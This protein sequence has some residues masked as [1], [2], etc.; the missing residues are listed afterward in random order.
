MVSVVVRGPE[1]SVSQ[2]KSL[3]VV[4]QAVSE[5]VILVILL[6]LSRWEILT[7]YLAVMI[8]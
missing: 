1:R 2:V 6:K 5:G 4:T 3:L 8:H 7:V